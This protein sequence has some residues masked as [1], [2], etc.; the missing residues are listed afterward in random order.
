[1]VFQEYITSTVPQEWNPTP[2]ENI[3]N[4]FRPPSMSPLPVNQE[5]L[6]I[7]PKKDY[8]TTWITPLLH[9]HRILS[10][11]T[12]NIRGRN[13][14]KT[15]MFR[16]WHHRR[17]TCRILLTWK[18]NLQ[19]PLTETND[20]TEQHWYKLRNC[21][22]K[23]GTMEPDKLTTHSLYLNFVSTIDTQ[24]WPNE[25]FTGQPYHKTNTTTQY[26]Y[27]GHGGI[28]GNYPLYITTK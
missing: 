12:R 13:Q 20:V 17:L 1:M 28:N 6:D 23:V 4:P 3:P 7:D 5:G 16:W 10:Y 9:R 11:K 18:T 8:G 24:R 21:R 22:V 19:P 27:A 25:S 2:V 26:H 14:W 15:M